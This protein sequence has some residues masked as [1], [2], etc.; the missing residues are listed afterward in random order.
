ML[1]L[2]DDALFA[3][4]NLSLDAKLRNYYTNWLP[5]DDNSYFIIETKEEYL[6]RVSFEFRSPGSIITYLEPKANTNPIYKCIDETELVSL[7]V[8]NFKVKQYAFVDGLEDINFVELK[9]Q[10]KT[11]HHIQTLAAR[12]WEIYHNLDKYP[13]VMIT[14]FDGNEF[15]ATIKYFDKNMV[16][17]YFTNSFAGIADLN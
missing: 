8:S 13:S 16:Q 9:G 4:V 2:I 12:V 7:M 3:G 17:I 11:Y 15:E 5:D 6:E 14:D 1:R 10:D